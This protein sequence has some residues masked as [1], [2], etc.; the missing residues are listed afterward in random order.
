MPDFHDQFVQFIATA[1]IAVVTI[2]AAVLIPM[3]IYRKQRSKKEL[4]YAVVSN[5][6]VVRIKPAIADR[7]E[8]LLDGKKIT[9]AR[10]A[11]LSVKN[12]GNVAVRREDY[13]EPI[14]IQFPNRE[15]LSGD[16]L[17]TEPKDLFPTDDGTTFLSL[18]GSSVTLK[19]Q[20]LNPREEIQFS[21]LFK[22]KKVEPNVRARIVG[23]VL[24]KVRDEQSKMILSRVKST[25][26]FVLGIAVTTLIP[27]TI[28]ALGWQISTTHVILFLMFTAIVLLAFIPFVFLYFRNVLLKK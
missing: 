8:I 5:A 6:P 26:A 2:V 23:G 4:S 16:V 20:L 19:K 18:D 21:V 28:A 12:T 13:D 25:I 15:I 3:W 14:T 1:G 11:V 24:I 22:G 17:S 10:L 7:I 9:D 27:P